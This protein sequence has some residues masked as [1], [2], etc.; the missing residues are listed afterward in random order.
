[1]RKVAQKP[2]RG[3]GRQSGGACKHCFQYLIPV[4]QLSLVNIVTVYF[5]TCIDHL[6]SQV[7][8]LNRHVKHMKPS[9]TTPFDV[10]TFLTQETVFQEMWGGGSGWIEV[11][12]KC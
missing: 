5:N 2:H 3:W 10:L 8:S 7:Q 4:Y 6:A 12:K 9:Y 1:M 11:F